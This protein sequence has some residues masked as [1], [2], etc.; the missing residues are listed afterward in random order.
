MVGYAQTSSFALIVVMLL[1]P[2]FSLAQQTTYLGSQQQP[3]RLTTQTNYE[4]YLDGDAYIAQTSLPFGLL[5]PA[6]RG[7]SL[8]LFATLPMLVENKLNK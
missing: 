2:A 8:S 1:F 6:G 7:F 5:V 3:I 4:R